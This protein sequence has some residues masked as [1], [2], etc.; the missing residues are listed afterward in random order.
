MGNIIIKYSNTALEDQ[1]AIAIEAKRKVK[2]DF[3][4]MDSLAVHLIT[5]SGGERCACISYYDNASERSMMDYVYLEDVDDNTPEAALAALKRKRYKYE[6]QKSAER[7]L[8]Y[9]LELLC[10]NLD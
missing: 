6:L 4:K 10:Q 5:A 1:D 2:E 3:D 9:K 7:L 8:P